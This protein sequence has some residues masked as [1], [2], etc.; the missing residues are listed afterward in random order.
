MSIKIG[1][2]GADMQTFLILLIHL[3]VSLAKLMGP[4]GAR[5]LVAESLLLKHQLII[6]HRQRKRSPNL[7][8]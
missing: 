6:T 7:T 4:G 1:D 5:G 3:V 8:V 2:P